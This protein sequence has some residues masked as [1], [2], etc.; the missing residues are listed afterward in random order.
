[1][2]NAKR[3]WLALLFGFIS[4]F[5]CWFLMASGGESLHW[6]LILSTITSRALIGFAIGISILKIK[7]WL[8]GILLGAI[9]SFPMGLSGLMVPGKE[10]FIFF[11]SIVMGMIYGLI[12][13]LIVS[14]I[15]RARTAT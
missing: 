3:F 11:G 12:I 15:F 5:I 6:A 10:M 4:G 14:V 9:I 8:H 1:M 7:W 2:F 13:E